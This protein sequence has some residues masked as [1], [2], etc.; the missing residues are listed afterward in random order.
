[1]PQTFLDLKR[2][3]ILDRLEELRPLAEEFRRLEE[4]AAALDGIGASPN[5]SQPAAARTAAAKPAARAAKK[6]KPA[7]RAKRAKRATSRRGG[8]PRGGGAR[9][10]QTLALVTARPGITI[11]EL[12]EAMG[13]QQN[14]LYRVLPNLAS[15]G[16]VVKSGRGWH[17]KEQTPA[18]Q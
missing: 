11:P 10:E 7:R 12:A 6:A 16:K 14:Y 9:T 15:E 17:P 13:I 1:M 8:R 5:G 4:A 18:A 2:Q 3:E